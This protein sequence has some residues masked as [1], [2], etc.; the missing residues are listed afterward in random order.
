M[1]SLLSCDVSRKSGT[2][3][4]YRQHGSKRQASNKT[5]LQKDEER[6]ITLSV[7][8]HQ[9][10][11]SRSFI[12]NHKREVTW[13]HSQN[14]IVFT[15]SI[16]M[17]PASDIDSLKISTYVRELELTNL[18]LTQKVQQ[19]ESKSINIDKFEN[20]AITVEACARMHGV[21]VQ[22][23]RQ[24][25]K[26]GYIPEHPD[27]TDRKILIRTSDAILLNFKQLRRALWE[28]AHK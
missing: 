19:L 15:D 10:Q 20:T 4:K 18:E 22:T 13:P 6:R 5:L 8:F 17:G 12:H 27:S 7:I 14:F 28:N 9:N 21:C 24:Y 11:K 16:D 1:G 2:F 25:I 3:R 23:V 26:D